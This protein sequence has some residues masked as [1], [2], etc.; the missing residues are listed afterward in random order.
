MFGQVKALPETSQVCKSNWET[1]LDQM[2]RIRA[3]LSPSLGSHFH[4]RFGV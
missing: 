3:K 4:C 1:E 2:N